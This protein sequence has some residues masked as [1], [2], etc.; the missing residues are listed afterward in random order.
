MLCGCLGPRSAA[1]PDFDPKQVALVAVLVGDETN[2]RAHSSGVNRQIEDVFMRNLLSKGY[3]LVSRS[4]IQKLL[5]EADFQRESALTDGDVVRIGKML[6]VPAILI[7]TVARSHVTSEIRTYTVVVNGRERLE[8]QRV[9]IGYATV[10]ARLVDVETAQ[11]LWVS[12]RSGSSVLAENQQTDSVIESI[13][14]GIA[15]T[16]PDRSE[17]KAKRR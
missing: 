3:K 4:D 13:A 17:T 16:I 2:G 8:K 1:S 11:V 12:S 7:A 9:Y 6:N 14:T 5:E 15:R 10:G